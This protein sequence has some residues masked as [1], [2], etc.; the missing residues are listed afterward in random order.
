MEKANIY[1][2]SHFPCKAPIKLSIVTPIYKND[3]SPL[4]AKISDEINNSN[5]DKNIEL[6]CVDD[7]SKS[8][9]LIEKI[10]SHLDKISIAAKLVAFVE[11]QGRS[12]ARNAL[13]ENSNGAFLLFLDSDM[14]PDCP[15]FIA[16][17][18]DFI[19]NSAPTIAYGGFST[20]QIE[21]NKELALAKE[22]AG[23]T[24]CLSA[25]ERNERGPLAV[26]TSNLLVRRDI[27]QEVPFDCGFK[28]WGWED[29]DWALRAHQAKFAIVHFEN[30]ATHLG[31][32]IPEVLLD[33]LA[34]AGPNFR[35]I[36]MRHPQMLKL[37]STKAARLIA[38][39]PFLV[40][41]APALKYLILETN[42]PIKLK[43]NLARLWRATHAAKS[44]L[45]KN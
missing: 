5:F 14:L 1:T 12:A 38:K 9:E 2:N 20:A 8:P 3:P 40:S 36:A 39:L 27:V 16:K 17:W 7:G 42:L 35:H 26:A 23:H 37:Q 41:F 44:I 34:Q 28:G 6:I 18:L 24:D 30:S 13:I 21:D 22:L 29:V 11:N 10:K 25:M 33:K 45:Q 19:D 32:D 15:N 31:L 43:A 4:L